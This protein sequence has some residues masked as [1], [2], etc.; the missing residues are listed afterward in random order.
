MTFPIRALLLA[1][2]LALV[3]VPAAPAQHNGF[4][5]PARPVQF[6]GGGTELFRALLDKEGIEPV[7]AD[8]AFRLRPDT[9]LIVV[10]IGALDG[11]DWNEGLR[12]A[13]QAVA[14]G[15]AALIAT[16]SFTNVYAHDRDPDIDPPTGRFNGSDVTADWR[17][18]DAA[19]KGRLECPF[20]VPVSPDELPDPPAKP[21]RV[22][23][24]F[25][26]LNRVV[27][28]QPTYFEPKQFRDEYQYPLA[29]FPKS[30][31]VNGRQPFSPPLLAVGGDGP[32][33]VLSPGYSFLAVADSSIYINQMLL[34][35]ETDNYK[36]AL[37]TVEYLQGPDKAR[38]RC[39]FYENGRVV[40]RFDVLREALRPP[41]PKLPPGAMPNLGPLF[42]KHQDKFTAFLDAKADELQG[43]DVLHRT[44]VGPPGSERERTSAAG[45]AERA[46]VV[47]AVAVVFVLLRRLWGGRHPQDTPPPPTTG[48]GAASTGPPGVFDRRQ[49]EMVR[50]NNVYEPVSHLV[51]EFFAAAG[52]PPNPGPRLPPLE[53]TRAIRKPESLRLAV[54]DMWRLAYGPPVALTAQR[55]FELEPYFDRL[56]QAHAAGKWYFV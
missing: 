44:A 20:A 25:R 21:G 2:A 55:W 27:T 35:P 8:E 13:R 34:E 26:G 15:G 38:K 19:S 4:P 33:R 6:P 1:A 39:V 47:A 10:V 40:D 50:R 49:R 32:A 43:R 31:R 17:A 52:A 5:E 12:L 24:V 3:A 53:V 7:T 41:R 9:G 28:N 22:W 46:A 11:N 45:W 29:R 36:F 37:R 30:A 14:A 16:D 48:A 56:K 54:R 18:P 51:R 42:G 23:A